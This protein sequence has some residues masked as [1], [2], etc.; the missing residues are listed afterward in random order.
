MIGFFPH[1]SSSW[2]WFDEGSLFCLFNSR[3]WY[4]IVAT[5]GNKILL[6]SITAKMLLIIDYLT[7]L[8]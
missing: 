7:R 6:M 5:H 4:K 2:M 3:K 1:V 8:H